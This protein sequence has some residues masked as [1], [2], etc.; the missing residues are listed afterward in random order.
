M[1]AEEFDYALVDIVHTLDAVFVRKD[2]LRGSLTPNRQFWVRWPQCVVHEK[3]ENASRL[4][5]ELVDYAV[6]SLNGEATEAAYASAHSQVVNMNIEYLLLNTS[7][8]VA[9]I[10]KATLPGTRLIESNNLESRL[11]EAEISDIPFIGV[12]RGSKQGILEFEED[13]EGG[14]RLLPE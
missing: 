10:I 14:A 5:S 3:V 1:V 12:A 2:Q 9:A 13:A 11:K 4:R 7:I 8:E 6:W